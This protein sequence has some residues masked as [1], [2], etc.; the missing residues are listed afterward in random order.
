MYVCHT[1]ILVEEKAREPGSVGEILYW[2]KAIFSAYW[3]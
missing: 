3:S 2:L 1:D